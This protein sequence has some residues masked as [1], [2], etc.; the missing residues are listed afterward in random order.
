MPNPPESSQLHQELRAVATGLE[1]MAH[2][3]ETNLSEERLSAIVAREQEVNEKK[4]KRIN[5]ILVLTLIVAVIGLG[6]IWTQSRANGRQGAKTQKIAQDSA[7]VADYVRDCLIPNTLSPEEKTKRCGS[8]E[9]QGIFF[10]TYF[11]CALQIEPSVRTDKNLNECVA[12]ATQ[13]AG[14]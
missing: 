7:I 3:V 6:G 14:G 5:A 12:K 10:V 11:N 8:S 9:A 2:A 4:I 13:A 1:M